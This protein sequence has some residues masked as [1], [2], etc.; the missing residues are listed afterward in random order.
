MMSARSKQTEFERIVEALGFSFFTYFIFSKWV[1]TQLPLSWNSG[2]NGAGGQHYVLVVDPKSSI[3]LMAIALVLGAVWGFIQS[4]DLA[5]M[6][7]VHVSE[8]AGGA[9][10]LCRPRLQKTD[11]LQ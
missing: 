8:R 11:S 6:S 2:S 5:S 10:M 1:S 7:E 9:D 3:L 4:H